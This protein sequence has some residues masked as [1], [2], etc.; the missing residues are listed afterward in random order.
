MFGF[1]KDK[2]DKQI[3][4]AQGSNGTF[5]RAAN[6]LAQHLISTGIDGVATFDSAAKVADEALKKAGS[7]EAAVEAIVRSHTKLAGANGFVTN[8]GGFIT[9]PVA[10]PAN[11]VGFYTVATR[12]VASIAHLYGHNLRDESVRSAIL[13]DLIGA[14][15]TQV[16]KGMGAFSGGV[17]TN[18]ATR[19]LPPAALAV[20]NKS[21]AF[22]LGTLVGRKFLSRIPRVIPV[23]GGF[24]GA[25]LDVMLL[26]KI[27]DAARKDFIAAVP[28]TA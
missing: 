16:L 19:R 22:R 3:E 7:R 26:R 24:I 28:P 10:L 2:D 23:A 25:G 21:V 6:S 27:A 1:G 11:I 15:A 4:P 12:M 13:L 8:L 14:D 5:N 18:V 9:M 17:A 20:V